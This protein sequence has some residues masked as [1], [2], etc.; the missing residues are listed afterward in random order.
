MV[1]EKISNL[2]SMVQVASFNVTAFSSR[3]KWVSASSGFLLWKQVDG[4]WNGY[5]TK[6]SPAVLDQWDD[7]PVLQGFHSITFCKNCHLVAIISEAEDDCEVVGPPDC[8]ANQR[9]VITAEN[10]LPD[11]SRSSSE[12][13]RKEAPLFRRRGHTAT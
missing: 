1:I 8:Q 6:M 12:C 4:K 5:S 7:D 10:G 9:E 13:E 2:H 11:S 3:V